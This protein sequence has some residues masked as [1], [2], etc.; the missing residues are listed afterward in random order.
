MAANNP[1]IMTGSGNKVISTKETEYIAPVIAEMYGSASGEYGTLQKSK[2]TIT[3]IDEIFGYLLSEQESV[4]LLNLFRVA[5]TDVSGVDNRLDA[6]A[7]V[8][9]SIIQD[10]SG[11]F[12][13]VIINALRNAKSEN[14]Y[15]IVNSIVPATYQSPGKYLEMEAYKDTV[16]S[17]NV[18]T[19]A[20]MLAADDLASFTATMDV[21]G[22]A[23][24]L[25]LKLD[26]INSYVARR[27]MY[28][29]LPEG[30]TEA[31]LAPQDISGIFSA[32]GIKQIDFLP[33]LVGDKFMCVFD[34]TVGETV[35]GE[36]TELPVNGA[37]IDRVLKDNAVPNSK[38]EAAAGAAGGNLTV[39]DGPVPS[40][41]VDPTYA[42]AGENDT[43]R[44]AAP[45]RRRIALALMVSRE[46]VSEGKENVRK[47]ELPNKG[48]PLKLQF[49]PANDKAHVY[50]IDSSANHFKA[51][52]ATGML[53]DTSGNISL[54][55]VD[56]S[57]ASETNPL[58]DL[59][60]A[61]T[62][63][64]TLSDLSDGVNWQDVSDSSAGMILVAS[65]DG[66]HYGGFAILE[67]HGA[68][69]AFK[70]EN[71]ANTNKWKLRVNAMIASTDT[72]KL[73][74]V[75]NTGR[76]VEK[77]IAVTVVVDFTK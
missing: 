16:A 20:N 51:A 66:I 37:K 71:V 17:L 13:N 74:Y 11:A 45:T 77:V 38:V 24:S 6:S 73:G 26:H 1:N 58:V 5:D 57:G 30:N 22:G 75:E 49:R 68:K 46:A 23:R 4:D 25:V 31:Y 33:F 10:A 7:N 64:T 50:Y 63:K 62:V 28:T 67:Q 42:Y 72:I 34:T 43:L 52:V 70:M 39:A 29:Q 9:V 54:V 65:M 2:V 41:S 44:F 12:K 76:Y 47:H 56:I 69:N 32:E 14:V 15:Q 19:L 48:A 36:N 55:A 61:Y 40:E 60:G 53:S 27:A 8:T 59:S 18:D 35:I 3:N 21:S